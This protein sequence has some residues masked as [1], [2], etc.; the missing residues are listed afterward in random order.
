MQKQERGYLITCEGIDGSGK[1]TLARK[2]HEHYQDLYK[3]VTLTR[4]PGATELGSQIRSM[5]QSSSYDMSDATEFLLF[6]ADRAQH[7]HQ[8][9]A[10][11][12]KE[13]HIIISDRMADSSLAYQGYGRGFDKNFIQYVNRFIMQS[14][15]PDITLYVRVD[16]DTAQKRIQKRNDVKTKFDSQHTSFFEKV[17]QGFD[18]IARQPHVITIDGTQDQDAVYKDALQ[19][20]STHLSI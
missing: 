14:Y 15:M 8:V 18:D 6:A 10:P 4:E 9:I 3:N 17:I 1:T 11:L 16:Y 2:I 12:L 5:V 19:A 20:L 13:K 7:I